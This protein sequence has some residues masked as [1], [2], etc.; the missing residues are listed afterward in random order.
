MLAGRIYDAQGRLNLNNLVQAGKPIE[1]EVATFR[2]LLEQLGKSTALA[3]QL[4]ARLVAASPPPGRQPTALPMKRVADLRELPGFDEDTIG[5]LREFVVFLPLR[6]GRT[7]VN[8]NTVSAELLAARIPSLENNPVRG[9]EI[10]AARERVVFFK[11]VSEVSTQL[12]DPNP[13]PPTD[14]STGSNLFLLSGM[15]RYER[16]VSVT[17]T[18]LYRTGRRAPVEVVWQDRY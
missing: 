3:D 11:Q 5:A 16:V 10:V 14:W 1:P 15:I 12:K 6:F 8:V 13:L 2:R 17:E 18:L 7:P 9:R 4:V